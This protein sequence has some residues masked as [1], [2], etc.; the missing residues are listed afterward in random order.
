MKLLILSDKVQDSIQP[1]PMTRNKYINKSLHHP[2]NN[3]ILCAAYAIKQNKKLVIYNF[4]FN[5]T[6]IAPYS[7]HQSHLEHA[8]NKQQ[9]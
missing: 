1:P 3:I 9:N 6:D 2:H 8:E 7:P 4:A 5:I